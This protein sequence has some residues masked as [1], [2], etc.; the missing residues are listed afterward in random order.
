MGLSKNCRSAKTGIRFCRVSMFDTLIFSLQDSDSEPSWSPSR[1]LLR[2]RDPSSLDPPS[3]DPPSPLQ[4]EWVLENSASEPEDFRPPHPD[5]SDAHPS[6]PLHCESD[7]TGW[8]SHLG[9]C[10]PWERLQKMADSGLLARLKEDG[11][12]P[13]SFTS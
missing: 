11:T 2:R 5:P 13:L 10:P 1:P 4:A 12:L 8:P 6:R 7:P 3:A 9:P